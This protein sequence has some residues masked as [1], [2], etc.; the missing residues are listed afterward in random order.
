MAKPSDVSRGSRAHGMIQWLMRSRAAGVAPQEPAPRG[1]ID[2][3]GFEDSILH[4]ASAVDQWLQAGLIPTTSG[5]YVME[6]LMAARDH[7]IPLPCGADQGEPD[8][9]TSDL[10]EIAHELRAARAQG[11]P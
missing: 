3:D 2:R 9:V 1:L 10:Q 11:P 5:Q 7:V 4:A 8:P 6:M